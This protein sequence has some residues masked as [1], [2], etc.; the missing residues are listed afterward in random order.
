MDEPLPTPSG[1]Q[2]TA[3]KILSERIAALVNY[4]ARGELIAI[5]TFAATGDE[6][7]VGRGQ[8]MR[9]DLSVDL[10]N[11][12]LCEFREHRHLVV[13]T[14]V[15]VQQPNQTPESTAI[16]ERVW[17]EPTKARKQIQTIDIHRRECVAWLKS[18]MSNTSVSPRTNEDLWAEAASRWPGTLSERE[19][20]RCRRDA[21]AGLNEEQRYIWAR[22]GP[23][24]GQS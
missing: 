15:F 3:S 5:G 22:P 12:D 4:L 13:W 16:P 21:L 6:R 23:K 1:L 14:G 18:I 7:P 10:S 2:E 19:F 9:K 8:W 20:G 11:S 24:R 17:D